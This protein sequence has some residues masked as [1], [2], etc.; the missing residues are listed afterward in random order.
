MFNH[1]GEALAAE[2][3]EARKAAGVA[4]RLRGILLWGPTPNKWLSSAIAG[5]AA[6]LGG[7]LCLP[8]PGPRLSA[9]R[10]LVALP[11]QGLVPLQ[12]LFQPE[13]LGRVLDVVVM[14]GPEDEYLLVEQLVLPRQ[15]PI[16]VVALV[17]REQALAGPGGV[18]L[19]P[20]PFLVL[21]LI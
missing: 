16:V 2:P 20:E 8:L 15:P 17:I 19:Q 4:G 3:K 12:F 13:L 5:P 7:R 21:S 6:R 11:E 14:Q 18:Q 9:F 1:G 10:L